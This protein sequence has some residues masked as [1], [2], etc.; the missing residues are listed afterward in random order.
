MIRMITGATTDAAGRLKT[1]ESEPFS[2]SEDA[3][4]RLVR[5]GVAVYV[6]DEPPVR[7]PEKIPAPEQVVTPP[8]RKTPKKGAQTKSRAKKKDDA[9][10]LSAEVAE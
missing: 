10:V 1:R 7:A 9:P 5:I 8:E 3:E 4:A 2:L 6:G